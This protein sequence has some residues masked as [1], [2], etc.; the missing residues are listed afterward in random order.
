MTKPIQSYNGNFINS[1]KTKAF[2]HFF[3]GFCIVFSVYDLHKYMWI[4]LSCTHLAIYK[5]HASFFRGCDSAQG[6]P[7]SEWFV[8]IVELSSLSLDVPVLALTATASPANTKKIMTSLCFKSDNIVILD[9]P[10]RE[11]MNIS[12]IPIPN[13]VDDKKLF[14]WMIK[15]IMKEKLGLERFNF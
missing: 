10:D 4:A 3:L 7:F 5:L 1:L 8:R 12:V 9:N 13:N 11:N 14:H 15:G 6:K 2:L